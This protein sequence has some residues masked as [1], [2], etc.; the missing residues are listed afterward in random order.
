MKKFLSIFI[1]IILISTSFCFSTFADS[2]INDDDT[3]IIDSGY[4]G[5]EGNGTNLTWEL[6]SLGTLTISGSG[7]M[8]DY[9]SCESPWFY[10]GR[11]CEIPKSVII[12]DDV[13]HIGNYAFSW[14]QGISSVSIGNGVKTIGIGSFYLVTKIKTIEFPDS[15]KTIE[16]QAFLG[17]SSLDSCTFGSGLETIESNAF[18]DCYSLLDIVL[19]ESVKYIGPAAFAGDNFESFIIPDG[20]TSIEPSTF[21]NCFNLKTIVIPESVTSIG[22]NAFQQANSLEKFVVPDQITNLGNEVFA[23][24]EN[25]KEVIIGKNVKVVGSEIFAQSKALESVIVRSMDCRITNFYGSQDTLFSCHTGSKTAS[26]LT[27]LGIEYNPIHFYEGEW[28]YNWDTMTRSRKCI[29]CDKCDETESEPLESSTIDGTEI[30]APFD[31]DGSHFEVDPISNDST[32]FV[33]I[34]E[35]LGGM[36][37]VKT[38]DISLRNQDGVHVQPKGTVK[39]KLPND[40]KT[41]VYKVYRINDDGTYTD[42]NAY[43]EGSHL[44]FLTDHFSLYA[45]VEIEIP[46][47]SDQPNE[48]NQSEN[49]SK[50][51]FQVIIQFFMNIIN[52]IVNLFTKR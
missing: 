7:K 41:A 47:Q 36:N 43:R 34:Q 40:F 33:L 52:R 4:C 25:L 35:A 11:E 1:S 22:N 10:R 28:V 46:D 30:I 32:E 14:Q 21:Q 6:D 17:C 51:I 44:V 37:I 20:I 3:T 48:P 29:Y 16:R 2:P 12:G 27:S 5:G 42:M 38:F 19:P 24:C 50:S 13:T 23:F 39:V 8:A 31:D 49:E 18:T 26:Y 45:I 15:L 9:S